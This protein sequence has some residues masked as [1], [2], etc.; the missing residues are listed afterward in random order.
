MRGEIRAGD[1]VVAWWGVGY[2]WIG[3][4]PVPAECADA[5][6]GESA[7]ALLV[8]LDTGPNADPQVP[9]V[10]RPITVGVN[11]DRNVLYLANADGTIVL[12]LN[13]T[14]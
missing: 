10:D 3:A 14:G 1:C 8:L 9:T 11:P 6:E 2:E 13:R 12:S 4:G 5:I 7:G